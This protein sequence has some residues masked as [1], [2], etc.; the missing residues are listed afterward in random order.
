MKAELIEKSYKYDEVVLPVSGVEI[1]GIF[2]IRDE[3]IYRTESI[4]CKLKVGEETKNFSF[5]LHQPNA[6]VV[7]PAD[8][9][10]VEWEE[11]TLNVST[12]PSGVSVNDTVEEFKQFVL[13]DI[14]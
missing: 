13:N 14:A 1:R 10:P 8:E 3:K 2:Y 11:P 12:W 6:G 7:R 4:Q 5:T 9:Q